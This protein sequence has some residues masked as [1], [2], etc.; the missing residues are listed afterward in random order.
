MAMIKQL[1][2]K[3]MRGV[4][5]EVFPTSSLPS[6]MNAFADI[7]RVVDK[8]DPDVI[9]DVGANIG[10]S[11][12][13]Y[14]SLFKGEIYAF[15]PV[16]STYK[17][18]VNN[19]ARFD[20]KTFNLGF[21]DDSRKVKIFLQRSAGLNSMAESLNTSTGMGYEEADVTTIDA[22]CDEQNIDKIS[23]LKIDTEGFGLKVLDGA[24]RMLARGRISWVFIEVGFSDDDKR[25]D[26]FCEV[27]KVLNQYSFSVFGFYDQWIKNSKLEYCNALFKH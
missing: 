20:V 24:R 4:G 19:V 18:L 1:T 9:F 14:R 27:S 2:K 11:S 25:H 26:N 13:K 16:G 5:I 21:G 8:F 17:A 6:G 10:Q 22:F 3:M 23:F 7:A 12:M 15:E